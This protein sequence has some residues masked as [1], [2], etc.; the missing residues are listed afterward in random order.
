MNDTLKNPPPPLPPGAQP[1]PPPGPLPADEAGQSPGRRRP[2]TVTVNLLPAG[3]VLTLPRPKT[4]L[5][6]LRRLGIPSGA[7]LVIRAGGLLTPDR[8]ILPGD[9]ITVRIVASSG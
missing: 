3:R 9:E 1:P 4:A 8:E 2:H 5:G 6:L 7:A